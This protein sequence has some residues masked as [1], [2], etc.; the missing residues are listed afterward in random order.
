MTFSS[1]TDTLSLPIFTQKEKSALGG[2]TSHL[3]LLL[4]LLADVLVGFRFLLR[5]RRMPGM[6]PVCGIQARGLLLLQYG[7]FFPGLIHRILS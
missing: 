7:F 6:L 4:L 2:L 5:N 1:D 3:D